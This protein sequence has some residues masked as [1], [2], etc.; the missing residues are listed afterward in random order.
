MLNRYPSRR[1]VI[2]L[3]ALGLDS[4]LEEG[5][6][7]DLPERKKFLVP[8]GMSCEAFKETVRKHIKDTVK[9]KVAVEAINLMADGTLLTGKTMTELYDQHSGDDRFLYI[10]FSIGISNSDASIRKG[11]ARS[12][13][14]DSQRSSSREEGNRA[15]RLMAK[16]PNNIPVIC[17]KAV[18]SYAPDLQKNK[19][20]VPSAMLCGDFRKTVLSNMDFHLATSSDGVPDLCLSV[21]S[22]TLSAEHSMK[23]I[24]E[25]HKADDGFLYLTYNFEHPPVVSA[26]ESDLLMA[27]TWSELEVQTERTSGILSGK[28]VAAKVAPT[29]SPEVIVETDGIAQEP[30]DASTRECASQ[31]SALPTTEESHK[32]LGAD[33]HGEAK[34]PS[35]HVLELNAELSKQA[36][37]AAAQAEQ[38][39]E[40]NVE[41]D[42]L[43]AAHA[44][45]L[46]LMREAAEKARMDA[47]SACANLRQ[48]QETQA[49][50]EAQLQEI[51]GSKASVPQFSASVHLAEDDLTLGIEAEEDV[52]A[53]GDVTKELVDLVSSFGALQAC[54]IGRVHLPAGFSEAAPVCANVVVKNEGEVRWP[55]TTVIINVDGDSFGLQVKA[56]RALLPG[57]EEEIMMDLEVSSKEEA[58]SPS[59]KRGYSRPRHSMPKLSPMLE[60]GEA[61][62]EARSVWAIIDAATGSR[63]GP[64]LVFEVLWDLP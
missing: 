60:I 49:N 25:Q 10:F 15:S 54:R 33:E 22:Q 56:L 64:L 62:P 36:E 4:G 5:A 28:G 21:N 50:L 16:H 47:S 14:L 8:G 48:V 63:L 6:L 31:Q 55:R 1:P 9:V 20:I 41:L 52:A 46:Q 23:Q 13:L 3:K 26:P 38:L 53:R 2:C 58:G 61:R 18:G 45:E 57:E 19:F 51:R 29:N 7:A 59:Q 37:L 30:K 35:T 42:K 43:K 34:M 32:V 24:Y 39:K 40:M 27:Q 11:P 44:E 12:P 17:D